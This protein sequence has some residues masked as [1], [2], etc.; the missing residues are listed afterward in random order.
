MENK[1]DIHNCNIEILN[2]IGQGI[3]EAVISY[4][5]IHMN[6][7]TITC[8][9]LTQNDD[10]SVIF[11]HESFQLWESQITSVLMRQSKNFISINKNGLTVTAIGFGNKRHLQDDNGNDLMIHPLESFNY[12]KVDKGNYMNYACQ[13]PTKQELQIF[14]ETLTG[15]KKMGKTILK[16]IY[17]IRLW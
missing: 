11:M 3:R 2:N 14:Q 4:K 17:S 6:T 7:Y 15:D 13:D 9:D 8:I 10:T 1:L 12:L 5:T 16:K